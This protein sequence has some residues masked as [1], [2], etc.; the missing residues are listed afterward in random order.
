MARRSP[1]M[2]T[3]SRCSNGCAVQAVGQ[4]CLSLCFRSPRTGRPRP[5][6]RA[7][8]D[9]QGDAREPA[10]WESSGATSERA[11]CPRWRERIPARLQARPRRDR[12]EAVGL[13]LPFRPVE[14]LAQIQ[15]PG[16]SSR[17]ARGR[18]G[19]GEGAVALMPY[20]EQWTAF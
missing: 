2:R 8:R 20:A 1:A 5:A 16:G 17:E 18:R 14:G 11:P 10:A 6:T 15:E 3:D 4:A 7:A 19:L 12:V 13:T 9:A